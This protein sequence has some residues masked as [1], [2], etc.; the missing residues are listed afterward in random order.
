MQNSKNAKRTAFISAADIRKP[1]ILRRKPCFRPS[2]PI[3]DSDKLQSLPKSL[4]MPELAVVN[5]NVD[6][7]KR[8]T[9]NR[10]GPRVRK[11]S[12]KIILDTYMCN[13]RRTSSDNN[14]NCD[15]VDT[16]VAPSIESKNLNLPI[17]E[18]VDDMLKSVINGECY[19]ILLLCKVTRCP[20]LKSIVLL[21][22]TLSLRENYSCYS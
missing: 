14:S 4:H 11:P 5:A 12:Q 3:S 20:H 17:V 7:L 13:K 9:G 8:E 15:A 16:F 10:D 19:S 2:N 18:E 1:N 21:L 6:G 22:E